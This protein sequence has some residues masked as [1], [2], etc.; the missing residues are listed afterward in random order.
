[1]PPRAAG[2]VPLRRDDD[3]WYVLI[4]RV[5]RNWDFPKGVVEPG[6]DD[7][8]TAIREAV[9]EAD[10]R[11]L[12][13]PWPGASFTTAPYSR[14]KTATYFPA[15]TARTDV[16]LPVSP[17]LG[18]PEHHEGRWVTLGAAADLLPSRLQPILQGVRD[19]L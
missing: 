8:A 6:E 17:E 5:Y 7:R 16:V 19:L 13:F 2:I 9:E 11:D 10:L 1:M 12:A 14:G 15:T 3:G 4:L 18:R